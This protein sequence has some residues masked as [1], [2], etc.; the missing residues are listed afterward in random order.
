MSKIT[1]IQPTIINVTSTVEYG[2]INVTLTCACYLGE[3][4]LQVAYRS[5][6]SY[7]SCPSPMDELIRVPYDFAEDQEAQSRNTYG[8][9]NESFKKTYL[10]YGV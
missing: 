3:D 2:Y 9:V 4:F 6:S 10:L 5:N 1:L 7:F 8:L